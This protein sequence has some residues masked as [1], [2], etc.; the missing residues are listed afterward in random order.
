MSW[1]VSTD[2][3]FGSFKSYVDYP[4]TTN[5]IVSEN[6]QDHRLAISSFNEHTLPRLPPE[7]VSRLPTG[8]RALFDENAVESTTLACVE[9]FLTFTSTRQDGSTY[10]SVPTYFNDEPRHTSSFMLSW[11]LYDTRCSTVLGEPSIELLLPTALMAYSGILSGPLSLVTNQIR[12][13]RAHMTARLPHCLTKRSKAEEYAL[14]WIFVVAIESWRTNFGDLRLEGEQLQDV[15][16]RRFPWS[17][18]RDMAISTLKSFF[19]DD[20]LFRSFR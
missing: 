18:H 14:F 7:I 20:N 6:R 17:S 11:N 19:H 13:C 8:I 9:R 10:L 12:G 15:M 4:A 2:L 5:L 16:L 1:N 3:S